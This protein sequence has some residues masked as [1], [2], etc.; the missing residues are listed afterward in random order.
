[1]L[2]CSIILTGKCCTMYEDG[3]GQVIEDYKR[4]CSE[5]PFKYQ[6]N[7]SIKCKTT[8]NTIN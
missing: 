1:M 6:S 3:I 5:C 8:L 4:E 7:D 2:P